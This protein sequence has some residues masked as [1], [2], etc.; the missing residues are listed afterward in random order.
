MFSVKV[1]VLLAVVIALATA[2]Y[3][4]DPTQGRVVQ[5]HDARRGEWPFYV[6]L[7]VALPQGM[8][9]C[10]GSLISNEWLITAA[11]CAKDVRYAKVHLGTLRA[12]NTTEEGRQTFEIQPKN[13]H[14]YPKFSLQFFAWK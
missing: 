9:S 2:E 1:V 14:V 4:I 13:I 11:H 10:G 8:G 12:H 5:G 6:L 7:E 3:K